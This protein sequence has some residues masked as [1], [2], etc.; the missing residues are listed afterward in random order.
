MVVVED[1]MGRRSAAAEEKL[2]VSLT[3][4]GNYDTTQIHPDTLFCTGCGAITIKAKS[5]E[6]SM[7][8]GVYYP[9]PGVRVLDH[10][11]I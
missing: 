11:V 9:L 8:N 2:E 4:E 6:D 3:D 10:Q 5:G 7:Y 1:W